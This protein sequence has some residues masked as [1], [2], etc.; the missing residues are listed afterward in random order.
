MS[1]F[2]SHGVEHLVRIPQKEMVD[3]Q[4]CSLSLYG[5][6]RLLHQVEQSSTVKVTIPTNYCLLYGP[7]HVHTFTQGFYSY[8]TG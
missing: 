6:N 5:S 7:G 4:A 1:L 2:G 3:L 8:Q